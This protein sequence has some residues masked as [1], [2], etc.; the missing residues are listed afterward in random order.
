MRLPILAAFAVFALPAA[1][2]TDLRIP[3]P[4]R[5]L[6]TCQD[7]W[8]ERNAIFKSFGYCFTSRRAIDYFGNGGCFT[9]NPRLTPEAQRQ[10]DEIRALE[11]RLG[12]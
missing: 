6:P 4:Q 11:R 9:S 3:A 7:L 12:C 8:V 2:Q 5:A 1:A 10:V